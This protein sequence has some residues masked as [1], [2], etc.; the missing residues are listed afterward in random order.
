[1][2]WG[3]YYYCMHV[4][5]YV[6]WHVLSLSVRTWLCFSTTS[7]LECV[8]QLPVQVVRACTLCLVS[9]LLINVMYVLYV[10]M[11]V[12]PPKRWQM[13]RIETF[14]GTIR[15]PSPKSLSNEHIESS[16]FTRKYFV[17]EKCMYV[18]M[19]RPFHAELETCAK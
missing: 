11:Y 8:I 12:L 13:N 1:M 9:Y 4:C 2:T 6:C 17:Y 14:P 15:G 10:C 18:Y 16:N 3:N 7:E 19:W 5:I